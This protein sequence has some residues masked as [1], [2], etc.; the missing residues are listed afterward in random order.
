MKYQELIDPELRKSAK[1]FPFNKPIVAAGNLYQEA[2]WRFVKAP[3]GLQEEEAEI[4]GFQGLPYKTTV[5]TPAGAGDRLPALLYVHGGAFAYKA[6]A[7]QKRLAMIY[8][9]KAECKVFFPHYHLAP[10]FRYPAAYEDVLALYRHLKDHAE[11]LGID[12]DRIGISGD[13]AGG[14][15]AALICCRWEKEGIGMPCLQMLAYPVTDAEMR[16]ESMKRYTDTPKWNALDNERMWQYYCGEDPDLR[17]QASPMHAAIPEKMPPTYIET[18]QFD[19]LHD[20]GL[21]FA[22]RV[23]EAGAD[24]EINDTQGTFHGYDDAIDTQIVRKNVERRIA[25]LRRWFAKKGR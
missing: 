17:K 18:A 25:F 4:K 14:S 10:K 24:V 2:D 6:A 9:E 11:A 5:F 23:K 22:Q 3:E 16:T 7:Y 15:I 8:A 13:S 21:L 1:S 19:C 12:P 20:E